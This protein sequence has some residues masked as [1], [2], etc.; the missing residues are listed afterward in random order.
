MSRYIDAEPLEAEQYKGFNRVSETDWQKGYWSG[1]DEMCD[2]IKEQP[3]ADV[4]EVVRCTECAM[5]SKCIME[6]TFITVG[7]T[8]GYCR[9]GRKVEKMT[10]TDYCT[11]SCEECMKDAPSDYCCKLE[12]GEHEFCRGCQK[13]GY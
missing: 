9:V 4:V 12:C 1:I 11:G 5:H 8:D 6:D 13:A 10:V 3:T 7:I 2:K